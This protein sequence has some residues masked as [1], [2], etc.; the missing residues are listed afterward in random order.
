MMIV[1]KIVFAL[2]IA[3]PSMVHAQENTLNQDSVNKIRSIV[4][5]EI[6]EP[7]L[8]DKSSSPDWGKI[9]ASV[10]D[11]YGPVGQEK[12]YGTQMVYYLEKKDWENFGKC[13]ALYYKTAYSR[14]EYHINNVTWPIFEHITDP[15]VLSIAA[16]T[17]KYSIDN[18][19]KSN[20]QAYDTYANLLYKAGKKQEAIEWQEKAVKALPNE[21]ALAET[22]EKMKKGEPTWN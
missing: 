13:Y 18:F 6:L 16:E 2:I 7:A 9:I 19:D 3:A 12:V 22:L 4:G 11:K 15:N 5:Q 20:Y 14:S 8:R 1:R 10:K 17:M 21:K